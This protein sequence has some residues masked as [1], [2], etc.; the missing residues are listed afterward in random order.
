MKTLFILFNKS[1]KK[2]DT[3]VYEMKE[4]SIIIHITHKV[5]EISYF[6]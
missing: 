4:S 3:H 6:D 1:T 2:L 5:S